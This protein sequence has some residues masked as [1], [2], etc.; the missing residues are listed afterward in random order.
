MSE[1][2]KDVTR[3]KTIEGKM[4]WLLETYPNLRDA[5]YN[6]VF[7]KYMEEFHNLE[8]SPTFFRTLTQLTIITFLY[9]LALKRAQVLQCLNPLLSMYRLSPKNG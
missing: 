8:I 2:R 4:A 3:L 7:A 1:Y 6:E 9:S 5:N